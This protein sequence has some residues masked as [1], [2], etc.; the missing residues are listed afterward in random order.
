M[1]FQALLTS[2][3]FFTC[4]A[5]A[6]TSDQSSSIA[7]SVLDQNAKPV[8]G[9]QVVLRRI[10]GPKRAK[11]LL[12]PNLLSD[13]NG[14]F[15]AVSLPSGT[16]QGCASL[17]GTNLLNPCEWL[18]NPPTI[19]VGVGEAK[20]NLQINMKLGKQLNV[21]LDDGQQMLKVPVQGHPGETVK[22]VLV[23]VSSPYGLH[24]PHTVA[25]DASGQTYTWTVPAGV[26]LKLDVW[27]AS[28]SVKSQSDSSSFNI[29]EGPATAA[30]AKPVIQTFQ[31][32]AADPVRQYGFTIEAKGG[33]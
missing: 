14:A 25:N 27:S 20:T 24:L 15:K 22:P 8:R 2:L 26:A 23:Q 3:C 32:N 28:L 13:S 33:K 16:Y 6:Q 21:R 4:G 29:N 12:P 18:Q 1:K 7:G 30:G 19:T 9:A 17:V 10:S 5:Q 11:I 31:I